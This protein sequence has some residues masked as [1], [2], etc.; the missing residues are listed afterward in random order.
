[1]IILFLLLV[2]NKAK[3]NYLDNLQPDQ[4]LCAVVL[5]QTVLSNNSNDANTLMWQLM[6]TMFTVSIKYLLISA[7][8]KQLRLRGNKLQIY[9]QLFMN[10]FDLSS[11]YYY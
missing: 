9:M 6:F 1:M 5:C 4:L 3:S 11:S 2:Q 8:H 7:K 10:K